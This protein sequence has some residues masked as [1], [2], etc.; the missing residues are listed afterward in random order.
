MESKK[1]IEVIKVIFTLQNN[2]FMS[3]I[4]NTG[5][6]GFAIIVHKSIS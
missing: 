3:G 4:F 1:L 5:L 2:I 6:N